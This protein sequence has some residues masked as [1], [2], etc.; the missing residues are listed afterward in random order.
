VAP[1]GAVLLALLP[2][3]VAVGLSGP[4][5]TPS[6]AAP[7]Q[8]LDAS[9]TLP[10]PTCGA[11][12][13]LSNLVGTC[14]GVTPPSAAAV[15]EASTS[16][17]CNLFQALLQRCTSSGSLLWLELALA[18]SLHL[19]WPTTTTTSTST[20]TTSSS[21]TTSST[22]TTQPPTACTGS[23]PPIAP[24]SGTWTCTL[25]D[26]FNGSSFDTTKWQPQLTAT[27]GYT[28]GTPPDQVCYVNKPGTISEAG[29][30]LNLSVVRL[31]L[32]ET[33]HGLNGVN[34][35][36]MYEGGM[37][38]SYKIFSQQY[39]YFQARAEMPASTTQGLQ[40]T[41]WLY[42][43]NQ[44]LY[45]PWP[46]SGEIDYAEFYSNFPN[47]DI[48]AIHYPGSGN[49]PNAQ[50]DNCVIAGQSPAGQF[51]TYALMW[52][53]T[54]MTTYYD[55]VPC[56]TDVY[57]P[58]VTSPDTAPEPFNQPFFLNFTAA[59]GVGSN[60]PG[61]ATPGRATTKLDWARVW[62]YG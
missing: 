34:S 46:D 4:G 14:P 30:Y 54:T 52:T 9:I 38:T 20:T 47:N 45:G 55:G 49:D 44:T 58:Y 53:P 16:S 23:A 3:L 25:D 27:S 56:M 42:P 6:L 18:S 21:T 11:L 50:S 43:E 41:L 31:A 40:E 36:A 2:I 26:E 10:A 1:F 19:T 33:C 51:H 35:V 32:P 28:T 8:G 29:G 60:S 22:T 57:A 39:G 62:Q 17:T 48:P 24:P 12:G 5:P 61:T 59:L 15:E 13:V 7:G 37:V